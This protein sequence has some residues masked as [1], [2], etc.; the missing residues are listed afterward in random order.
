[1]AKTLELL[2]RKYY[3]PNRT[4]DDDPDV[5]VG[6]RAMVEEY[7]DTCAICKRSKAP[8]HKPYGKL[9][10]LPVPNSKWSDLTMDFVTGLPESRDWNGAV[11]DTILVVVD[12]LTK[13][14]H[15]IPVTKTVTAEDLAE[16]LTREIVRLHGLPT[17]IVTD[18]GSLFT[19]NYYSSLCYALNIK[20]KLSTAF[21]PQTD[22]QTERQN[23][24]ME[25]YLRAFVN[26]EQTDWVQL[27]PMAEFAYNNAWN[28]S[29]K[30]SPFEAMQGYSPRMSFED[31][32]DPRA[33]SKSAKQHAKD[34]ED[35]MG[36]L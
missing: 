16:I 8:R 28:A 32:P 22:G 25:Q 27:L 7:C 17:S 30:M 14:T 36:V 3:W 23:S 20:R 11:Y 2:R 35:L 24:T 1:M 21:H 9:Q 5:A 33:K 31:P 15:Y 19:S 18:R 29:A 10:S 12:R 6:M 34:M 13:M 4:K 26:F